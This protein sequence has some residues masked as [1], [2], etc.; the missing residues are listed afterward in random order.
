[1]SHLPSNQLGIHVTDPGSLASITVSPG[2]SGLVIGVDQHGKP[3][4]IKLFRPEPTTA[5]AV[6]GLRFAQLIAFR[7]LAVGAQIIVQTGRPTAWGTFGR[8]T[9]DPPDAIRVVPPGTPHD[10]P[11]KAD[12]P[13][14]VVLD[15][16]SSAA[17]SERRASGGWAAVLTVRDQL[18]AWDIDAFVR[19]DIVLMQTLSP[20]ES[21]LVCSAL[22]LADIEQSLTRLPADIV[23]LVSHGTLRWARI[24]QTPIEQ[25]VIGS[26][27]RQ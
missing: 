24:A 2:G 23:T 6:G 12:R 19:A 25:Q 15:G 7:A 20:V 5:F 17:D 9:A 8:V 3:V 13:V 16:D 14:L 11:G 27:L 22:N 1:M 21:A 26:V 18:T 4:V 10:R